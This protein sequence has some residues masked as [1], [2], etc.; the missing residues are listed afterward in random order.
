[1][2]ASDNNEALNVDINETKV[3]TEI[4]QIRRIN[5]YDSPILSV[6]K[7]K[8]TVHL[9]LDTGATA[10][11]MSL[12]KAKELNLKI[13]PT[14]HKAVQVD[15]I[16]GLKV[17]GEVHTEFQRG[18]L[19]FQFSGLVVNRL[20]TDVL[21]G[22]G[23]H[24]ENDVYSR[25]SKNMICVL[26]SHTFQST[27]VEVMK[28]DKKTKIRLVKVEQNKC[29]IS[30][31]SVQFKLPP[32]CPSN[33]VFLIEPKHDQ[34]KMCCESQI[35]EANNSIIEVEIKNQYDGSPV[36]MK[37][38]SAPFQVREMHESTENEQLV[39]K[40]EQL[41]GNRYP[42]KDK[43]KNIEVDQ[44]GTMTNAEKEMFVNTLKA[45][46]T[47]F[48][49]SLPG[50]NGYYG[51]VKASIQFASRARPTQHKARM[52][53]YGEH[54]QRLYD[55]KIK[56][57]LQ[58]GILIDPFELGIQPRIVN[59]SWVIR[60]QSAVHKKWQ[61]CTENDVRLITGFDPVNK[62][63]NQIPSKAT[64]P[65]K[66]YTSLAN[67]KHIA[68]LDFRDFY[69]QLCFGM[70]T[71]KE[72]RQ[73]E[74][75]CIRTVNGTLA[76]SRAPN[77]LLGMDA[78]CDEL[79]DKMFGDLVLQ[80]KL[81]KL[82]DNVYIGAQSIPDLHEILKDVLQRCKNADLRIKPS[83][84]QINIA[85]AD[86]LGLHWD[87]GTL[88]P[89]V[90]KLEPLSYCD[91]PMTV[92]GLR[93][94]LG[95]VRFNEICLNSKQL[96]NATAELDSII[97]ATRSGKDKI[98]WNENL[99]N[100]FYE[101][102]KIC[103]NPET[104]FVPKK[105]DKLFIVGDAAP[106]CG[107]GIGSKLL[108]QRDGQ[109]T[110]LPSFNHGLRMKNTMETWSPCEVESFQLAQAIRKFRPFIRYVEKKTTALLDSRASVLAIHRLE[111]GQPSTN[112]RLQ[113]LLANVT[114]ENIQ[115]LH[116][117]AKLPS[118][119]LSYVDFAS[120]NPIECK[121][122]KCTICKQS[123]SPDITFFGSVTSKEDG[124]GD[125]HVTHKMWKDIQSSSPDLRK[126]AALMEAGKTPHRKEKRATDVSRYLRFC[127]LSKNGLV[128]AKSEDKSQPFLKKKEQRIVIPREFSFTFATVLH[129]RY[130]HP[131]KSQM[132]KTFNRKF[133]MLNA[134]KVIAEAT[135]ACEY[136]C[137]AM[138]QLPKET[139]EFQTETVPKKPGI[140]FNADVM[141][142]AQQ[143][144][145]L[146][147][148]NLTSFTDAMLIKNETKESLRDALLLL[149]IKMR[150]NEPII[151]RVDA[152]STLKALV[153]DK[154]L[155]SEN[156]QLEIGSPKNVN[157]NAVAERA[158][159]ELRQEL[160]R[161]TPAGGKVSA[162]ALAK[163]VT[164]LNSRIRH[165]GC[166]SKELWTK[167]DQQTGEPL[168]FND[169]QISEIQHKMRLKSH[170]PS[171]KYHSRNAPKVEFPK[172]RI[173]DRV[174]V[175][176]DGAKNHARDP[177]IILQFIP[178]KNEVY[179]QKLSDRK[180]KANIIPIHIQ[181]LYKVR[182]T[183]CTSQEKEEDDS[184]DKDQNVTTQSDVKLVKKTKSRVF[185]NEKMKINHVQ[186]CFYCVKMQ[187][188][189]VNHN[190]K[191][192]QLLLM[193][194]PR[195]RIYKRISSESDTDDDNYDAQKD[196][197]KEKTV[198]N[199]ETEIDHN[200][201]QNVTPPRRGTVINHEGACCSTPRARL[202][203]RAMPGRPIE[204]RSPV[205][206][207]NIQQNN[208]L[209]HP[210]DVVKYLS[211]WAPD[212][213][214]I[215][216]RATVRPMTKK[217]QTKYPHYYNILNERGEEKSL[218]LKVGGAWQVLRDNEFVELI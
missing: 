147:R 46:Y 21:A 3:N 203:G 43:I 118:P 70:E 141:Q 142:E 19:T 134:E 89:S 80:G 98:E 113:D 155:K 107:P 77:G 34:G 71:W 170:E 215:W 53:N 38:N 63:L 6:K 68:Q 111:K 179:A 5:I 209:V 190:P 22:T 218:E 30:G 76:Y 124:N 112:R 108:I 144:I 171:A 137:R 206:A 185:Y 154:D 32:E 59:D 123:E 100:A 129:R 23:F 132:L 55:A 192:C 42:V 60:K 199:V 87:Q 175:K 180:N 58:K 28:L 188:Q 197:M 157:K 86:I 106:S 133:Y 27:P 168:E 18:D 40:K 189:N 150:S 97:P 13:L 193:V 81:A 161:L 169:D 52:P 201:E 39:T 163:A 1:M 84:I 85:T 2:L 183:S 50:Y 45:N 136:P 130:N 54:G 10:S 67:W 139:L 66:I 79:T 36:K 37:K 110:L 178:N 204:R 47:L 115:V 33:G 120:R 165:T 135:D 205:E 62:F 125:L 126:A 117:S 105:T 12:E 24:L 127:T 174:Y 78:V 167:R 20:G 146:I 104:V 143:K 103:K 101:V 11:L 25:M 200:D 35:A 149:S 74:Y 15:G 9:V 216:L 213:E 153:E 61:D 48:D 57:M 51:T 114:A 41:H 198:S 96:A 128:I 29:V 122:S 182:D 116:M 186:K 90:H 202:Y 65:M 64:D 166:S 181:N 162:V 44:A 31:D 140:H 14:V 94:F 172:L 191:Q 75:L 164:N 210:G 99:N 214:E 152:H 217:L 131:T 187:K 83:K 82:A 73:L 26:G 49:D 145:L 177:Y 195:K 119:I 151:I 176:S 148:E 72:K 109:E 17:I 160:V 7:D 16:S 88:T 92:K 95:A 194:K 173:G 156:V 91:K 207:P 211:G 8:Q 93:S 184:S 159:K 158:I 69:W 4:I 102:Q 196:L 56:S 208:R 212:G 138:K 121:N